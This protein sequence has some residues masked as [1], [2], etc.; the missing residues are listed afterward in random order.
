[1][2]FVLMLCFGCEKKWVDPT[3]P[4]VKTLAIKSITYTTAY[5]GG[6]IVS[7]GGKPIELCGVC[8]STVSTSPTT[9]DSKT[10]DNLIGDS[11][12]VSKIW[13]LTLNTTYYVRAYATNSTGTSYGE[14]LTFTTGA[15]TV[16]DI[17]GNVYHT[18]MI[19]EHLWM[20]ENLRTTR[21]RDGSAIA[22]V[23]NDAAWAGLSSGAYS[24]YD[25]NNANVATYGYL[26]NW[27]AAYDT[28]ICPAGWHVAT[29]N[30]WLTLTTYLGYT[31]GGKLKETGTSHW[32]S[33]NTGATNEL[34]FTALP[35]GSRS[36]TGVF[37]GDLGQ[38]GYWWAS[39]QLNAA[40]AYYHY[41]SFD[42]GCTNPGAILKAT[43]YSVRCV[44]N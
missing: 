2:V 35:G 1:M 9:A 4:V 38:R 16:A 42:H 5:S 27:Y 13:D 44:M 20:V 19:G 7:N 23:T 28:L 43:G 33:P 17:D 22:Q 24:A 15:S 8:Y 37:N 12:F 31:S 21:Y 29:L 3:L 30:D 36:A 18:I 41:M 26:Y 11:C 10:I 39:Y 14:A 34:G 40:T 6:E 25:N 32:A